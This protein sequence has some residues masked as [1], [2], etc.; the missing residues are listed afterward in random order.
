VPCTL[1]RLQMMRPSRDVGPG[2]SARYLWLGKAADVLTKA[3]PWLEVT[4]VQRDS[5]PCPCWTME[6]EL[7]VLE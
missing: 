6:S 5:Y 7:V 3:L 2:N 4:R 1:Q